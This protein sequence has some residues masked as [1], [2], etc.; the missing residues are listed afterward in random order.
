MTDVYVLRP[1]LSMSAS[2]RHQMESIRH[3]GRV[4]AVTCLMCGKITPQTKGDVQP[5]MSAAVS[6]QSLTKD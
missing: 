1:I 6:C 3:Q 2:I 4:L 5:Y